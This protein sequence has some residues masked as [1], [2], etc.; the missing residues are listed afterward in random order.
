[1]IFKCQDQNCCFVCPHQSMNSIIQDNQNY[2][3]W[4]KRIMVYHYQQETL[5][6]NFLTL[7]YGGI[8]IPFVYYTVKP[9]PEAHMD[10]ILF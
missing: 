5:T 1:M 7:Y 2:T 3:I 9:R 6:S 8:I 4:I 10:M